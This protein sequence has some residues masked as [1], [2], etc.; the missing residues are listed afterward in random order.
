VS[1][2]PHILSVIHAPHFGGPQARNLKFA[3]WLA[4][5]GRGRLTVA[6]PEGAAAQRLRAAGVDVRTLPLQRLRA[7][8]D[9]RV[10]ARTLFGWPAD[11]ARLTALVRTIE[12]DAVLLNGLVNAQGAV[13]ARRAGV[14]VVWQLLD[15]RT[16]PAL[17]RLLRPLVARWA[18]CVMATG[19]AVAERH[20]GIRPDAPGGP[21]H[22]RLVTFAPPVDGRRF[23]PDPAMA[24]AARAELGLG[25]APVVGAIANLTP[26]KGLDAFL[27][28]ARRLR[29]DRPDVRFLWLGQRLAGQGAHADHL[30]A[31]ARRL[32]LTDL[33]VVDPGDRVAVLAQAF[34]L[35]WLTSPPQ[36]EG[37]PTAAAESMALGVPLLG[38]DVGAVRKLLADGA[39]GHLLAPGDTA[40]LARASAALLADP[41]RAAVVGAAGRRRAL[42]V[43]DPAGCFEAHLRAVAIARARPALRAGPEAS[44]D[45]NKIP[46]KLPGN[47]KDGAAD[48]RMQ[49][50]RPVDRPDG[51][52][53][54]S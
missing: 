18:D 36:S 41:G 11:V 12:A 10:Q 19:A 6:L 9:P 39:T 13:A 25:A 53:A 22:G 23:A 4:E 26:Q 28:G 33:V 3:R 54:W 31:R 7:S 35:A 45:I 21:L 50:A 27:D 44:P 52:H 40:G 46:D 42:E 14:P 17:V 32:G 24:R 38:F 2:G 15:T 29:R 20:F 8:A 30:L 5:T 49:D 37:I 48:P 51:D 1:A 47:A 34:D 16:P 43:C